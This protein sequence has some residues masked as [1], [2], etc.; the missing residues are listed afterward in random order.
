V[1]RG[2]PRWLKQRVKFSRNNS[3]S[4][5]SSCLLLL[6]NIR[7]LIPAMRIVVFSLF[8]AVLT[9]GPE[10]SNRGW[11]S[12]STQPALASVPPCSLNGEVDKYGRCICDAPWSG[13]ACARLEFEPQPDHYV[14][15]YGYAPNV[16][17]WGGTAVL[18]DDGKY[19]LFVSEI[20]GGLSQWTHKSTIV[21]AVADSPMGTFEKV[22]T[23]FPAQAH[24]AAPV[25]APA[26]HKVCPQ[27]YYLFHI[28]SSNST[29]GFAHRA[30][31]PDGPWDPVPSPFGC[32]NPAPAF[33]A[34]GTLFVVC[35]SVNIYRA[36]DDPMDRSAWTKITGINETQWADGRYLK[37]ED[38][39]LWQ[40]HRGW[41]LLAHRY[42]YRDGYPPNPDQT[43]PVLVA[44]HAFSEDLFTWHLSLEPPFDNHLTFA[45]GT[46]QHFATMERPHLIF[47]DAGNPTHTVHGVSPVWDQ[48][49]EPCSVCDARPGSQHSCVVCKTS[50]GY[51][52]TYT[53]VQKLR[54]S[55]YQS[56]VI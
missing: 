39:Y 22:G 36:G 23:P 41:H 31:S 19:H 15:A 34:N 3:G 28:G 25:R 21:H 52:W 26:S 5:C 35:N 27:C 54:V 43:M 6:L 49:G 11:T 8:T 48:Y 38:A 17:S 30:T 33:D 45:N 4:S 14:P 44:G 51:D 7:L 53:L 12:L 1:A 47:N 13:P 9:D 56:L 42:D 40:G 20:P 24:N 55:E 10:S 46:V 29:S 32:N 18:G 2:S 16:T 37:V 50:K